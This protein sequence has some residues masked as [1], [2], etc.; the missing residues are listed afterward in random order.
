MARDRAPEV[1]DGVAELFDGQGLVFSS[2]TG[3]VLNH[4]HVSVYSVVT[5]PARPGSGRPTR[6][7]V[8]YPGGRGVRGPGPSP[9]GARRSARDGFVRTGT[10]VTGAATDP[11]GKSLTTSLR[12]P[13]SRN[14]LLQLHQYLRWGRRL[15]VGVAVALGIASGYP[16]STVVGPDS[17]FAESKCPARAKRR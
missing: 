10:C 4:V 17:A 2:L 5:G 6:A 15:R 11:H 8:S 3:R 16:L 1:L 9:S 13:R 12:N 14:P 7:P